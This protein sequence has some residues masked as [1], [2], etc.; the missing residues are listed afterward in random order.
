MYECGNVA[1][2]VCMKG[3]NVR[4]SMCVLM[5]TLMMMLHFLFFWQ[6]GVDGM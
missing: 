5:M 6:V 2:Y 3:G 1:M 4:Q